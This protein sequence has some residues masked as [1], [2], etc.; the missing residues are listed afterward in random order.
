MGGRE[1][2]MTTRIEQVDPAPGNYNFSLEQAR[3]VMRRFFA[4][5]GEKPGKGKGS[6]WVDIQLW[7]RDGRHTHEELLE[8]FIDYLSWDDGSLG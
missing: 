2:G 1:T 3:S 7:D 6:F 4:Y 5:V 8:D